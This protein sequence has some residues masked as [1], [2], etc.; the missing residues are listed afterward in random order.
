MT[1]PAS[2]VLRELSGN[3]VRTEKSA[4][5]NRLVAIAESTCGDFRNNRIDGFGLAL[6][7]AWS[8]KREMASGITSLVIDELY[9]AA[10]SAGAQGGK[11]LGAGGGG[12]FLFFAEPENHDAIRAMLSELR[13]MRFQLDPQGSRI[14]FVH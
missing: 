4:A 8:L 1:R 13:E 2:S 7:E 11:L 9:E 12:F 3:L 10:T 14:I 6:D 5:M